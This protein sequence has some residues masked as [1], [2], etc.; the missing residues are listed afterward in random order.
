MEPIK[1]KHFNFSIGLIKQ[2]LLKKLTGKYLYIYISPYL[3][4]LGG[5]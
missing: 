4:V 2:V 1:L 3:N 5:Q